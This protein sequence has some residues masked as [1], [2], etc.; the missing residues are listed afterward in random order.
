[1]S[2]P[3]LIGPIDSGVS[4]M[5]ASIRE[6]TPYIL[7]GQGV[8]GG[9][10]YYW[11]ADPT[12]IQSSQLLPVF[13]GKGTI[14]SVMISDATNGGGINFRSDG[15]TIGNA[16]QPASLKMSESQYA[17]WWPPTIFLSSVIYTL[18]APNGTIANILATNSG[19][20]P[21]IPANNII[22]LPV[23]WY[24][25]CV[26]TTY[27]FIN[28]PQASILNWF[29]LVAPNLPQCPDNI[30]KNGWT[31]LPDC[32]VGNFY[33]Y[34][35]VN[36]TCGTTGMCNGPCPVIYDDCNY[37]ATNNNY[38]CVFDSNKFFNE[39]QWWTTPYFIGAVIAIIIVIIIIFVLI[40]AVA[41]AGESA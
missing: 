4:F 23:L 27:S 10:I 36:N 38:V 30:L 22:I 5:F 29:C 28:Q 33:N 11:E 24:S 40:V 18:Y 19:T 32:Q 41:R 34:C 7:N 15:I 37:S 8:T 21:T 17:T 39:T 2:I 13:S 1:M 9:V 14:G 35:P 25:Q 12:I 31:N 20:G 6:E 26:G 16:G 3:T